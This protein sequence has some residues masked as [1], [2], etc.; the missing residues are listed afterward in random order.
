MSQE[1]D[2]SSL[3]PKD[4]SDFAAFEKNLIVRPLRIE[5]YEQVVRLQLN[6][7]PGMWPW[8][9]EQIGS[10]LKIFPEGQICIEYQGRIIASASSLILNLD[11]YGECHSWQE[12]SDFGH[13]RNHNPAGNAL[14]GIEI[15]VD[16]RYRG[17]KL[18]RRLYDARKKLAQE[19]NL[20]RIVLGGRIP[21]YAQHHHEMS[22]EE[23]VEKVLNKVFYDPVLTAQIANGFAF[24]RLIQSYMF[25]DEE[26]RA[27]G[28]LLEWSNPEYQPG[29]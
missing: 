9:G 7:F 21:G 3:S 16:P 19:R 27:Y 26:S 2:L 18:A 11:M 6:C 28:T 14:Y 10:Q 20:M 22:A 15:M 13:I 8:S 12:I 25:F 17:M 23:Y 29:M 1:M 24:K 4:A 5:D